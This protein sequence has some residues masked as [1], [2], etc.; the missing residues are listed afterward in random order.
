[1]NVSERAQAVFAEAQTLAPETRAEFVADACGEDRA[2]HDEVSSLLAASE[3]ADEYFEQLAGNVGLPSLVDDD[4]PIATGQIFGQWRVLELIA[5]GGMGSIYRAE[6]ADGEYEQQVALK[7]LPIGLVSEEARAR[8][9]LERQIL[10]RLAHDSIARLLDGGVTEDGTPYFAMEY[11]DGVP[12]DDYCNSHRLGIS[13][14][15]KLFREVCGAVQFAHRNLIVHRDLKPSNVLVSSDGTVK[16][17]DFGIAKVLEGEAAAQQLTRT[18]YSP[19][20]SLYASPEM[21]TQGT[22]TTLSDVYAL[23]VVLYELLAGR[24]PYAATQNAAGPAIWRQICETEPIPP[25][26]ACVATTEDTG[27][28]AEQRR[29]TVRSLQQCLRGDLDTIVARAMEKEP[30]RRYQSVEQLSDDLRRYQEGMPVLARPADIWYRLRKFA[31]RRKA[32]VAA[33]AAATFFIATAL[34]QSRQIALEAER[35]NRE[36]DVAQQVSDYLVSIFES[37]NPERALGSDATARELLERGAAT[38]RDGSIEDPVVRGRLMSTIAHVMQSLSIYEQSES[39]FDEALALQREHLGELD[40]QTLETAKRLGI[41]YVEQG[42]F[43]AAETA[44]SEVASNERRAFGLDDSRTLSTLHSLAIA[45]AQQ[46]DFAMAAEIGEELV[47]ARLRALGEEHPDTLKSTSNLGIFYKM[48]GR[49]AEAEA[50]YRR[51]LTAQ[52][53]VLPQ[54]HPSYIAQR[55]NLADLLSDQARYDEATPLY[56]GALASALRTFGSEHQ[57]TT[58]LRVNIAN[59]YQS[60]GDWEHAE[61]LY[62]ET[63]TIQREL[64]GDQHPETLLGITKLGELQGRL[65]QYEQAEALLLEARAGFES[66]LGAGHSRT[67]DVLTRLSAVYE[68]QG[69]MDLVRPLTE[70]RIARRR[71]LA[72]RDGATPQ[73]KLTFAYIL[74]TCKPEDLRDAATALPFALASNQE[75]DFSNP[76]FVHALALAYEQTGNLGEAQRHMQTAIELLPAEAEEQRKEYE[77][78]LERFEEN[79]A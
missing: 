13:A 5:R 73:D 35:A 54:D 49:W 1:M 33:V 67:L 34:F 28:V 8:F 22:V 68:A 11:V 29:T 25:S 62:A 23:G 39:L 18:G 77:A 38:L 60:M 12:L 17:V 37:P 32:V 30:E 64:L 14:R 57:V 61:E 40:A 41:L 15:L 2:L 36:A 9:F 27:E 31:A 53:Q 26:R 65:Q 66:T 47:S 20:T 43:E 44:L 75:T 50:I 69:Q 55:Q 19:M 51:V 45:H 16:L 74:V 56:D 4:T 78:H 3:Q 76:Q 7:I 24:G 21:L 52:E 71:V 58:R 63:V 48:Q 42:R 46:G 6:R 79:S 72:E 59:M 10:A 70:E